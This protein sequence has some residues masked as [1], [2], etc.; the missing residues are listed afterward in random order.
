MYWRFP[1][2]WSSEDYSTRIDVVILVIELIKNGSYKLSDNL[3]N[4]IR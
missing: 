2:S 3:T 1:A 4:F